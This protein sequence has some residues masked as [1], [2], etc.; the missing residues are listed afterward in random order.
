MIKTKKIKNLIKGLESD[1]IEV[2][3]IFGQVHKFKKIVLQCGTEIKKKGKA[4]K[5]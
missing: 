1:F 4:R 5:K 2:K 3:D